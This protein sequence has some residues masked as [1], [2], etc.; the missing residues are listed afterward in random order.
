MTTDRL[1]RADAL[2]NRERILDTARAQIAC[3]GPE[4]SMLEIARGA[5]VAVGTLYRHYPTKTDLVAEIIG[6]Q[7]DALA[8]TIEDAAARVEAG[9]AD[10]HTEL[11]RFVSRILDEGARNPALKAAVFALLA[12][13]SF[14]SR[15]KRILAALERLVASGR[16]AGHL[17]PDLRGADLALLTCSGP[18]DQATP[19]RDRWLD[20]VWPGLLAEGR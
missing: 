3:H 5:G 4:V 15:T 2:R 1:T 19:D 8:A 9:L 16:S 10:A 18:F 12:D 14:A 17:R 20:L 7:I 6:E 11:R 13:A